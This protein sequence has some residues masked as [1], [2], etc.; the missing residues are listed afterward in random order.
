[1][2]AFPSSLLVRITDFLCWKTTSLGGLFGLA[3][4]HHIVMENLL[5]G[6]AEGREAGG[7]EWRTYDL[8]PDDYF[9]PERDIAGGYLSTEATKDRLVDEFDGKIVLTQAEADD[10]LSQLEE[11]TM[12]LQKSNAVDY[13]LFLVRI[14]LE[15]PQNPFADQPDYDNAPRPPQEPPLAPPS[16]PTWRTGIKSADDKYVFRAVILDFFWAKHTMTPVI[17]TFLIR[18]WNVVAKQGP[19]SITTSPDEYR[20]RF[21]RMCNHIV[22]V[23]E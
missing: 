14:P 1:M 4:T 10:F 11:D 17:M 20:T 16:P 22:E 18:C 12:V 2:Q 21:L 3:P 15:M 6:E 13:S 5:L 7:M 8:K 23:K 9:F 19:M